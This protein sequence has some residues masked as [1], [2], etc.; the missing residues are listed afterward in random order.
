M[1]RQRHGRQVALADPRGARARPARVP[2]GARLNIRRH[3]AGRT[4]APTTYVDRHPSHQ[5]YSGVR[6]LADASLDVRAGEIHALVGENGAGKSTL[7]RVLTGATSPDA[8]TVVIDGHAVDRF[9]PIEARRLGVVAIHQHPA[10]FPDL[11]VA[12]NLSLGAEPGGAF[13][14]V[15]WPARRAH[16]REALARVGA[17]I[18]VDREAASLSL[19]EQQL[20]EMARALSVRARLLILDEP[21]ASLTPREVDRLFELLKELRAAGVAIVYISH[22]LEELP[23]LADRVTVLRDG[24]TVATH[25]MAEVDAAALIKLMV[26]RD[27]ASVFPKRQVAIGVPVLEVEGLSSREAGVSDISLTVRRGEIV[28]LAGLV[29]AGRTELAR[30][31]FGLARAT[32]DR[33]ASRAATCVRVRRRKPLRRASRTFRKTAAVTASCSICRSRR[34]SH[35]LRWP[36]SRGTACSIGPPS[37]RRRRAWWT[38]FR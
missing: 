34:T 10:L 25:A 38:R 24:R 14:R 6:A 36:W 1:L 3:A 2:P 28:G 33:Y 5:S 7:V 18:D 22:R 32:P 4:R 17:D 12:E 23:R 27:V 31:L 9:A 29:G 30:V 26:G 13:S 15:D 19:P 20:V 21:T 11:S 16:A 37:A 8:G 35:W